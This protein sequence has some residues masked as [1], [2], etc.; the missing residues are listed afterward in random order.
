[1]SLAAHLSQTPPGPRKIRRSDRRP[2]VAVLG[3][4]HQEVFWRWMGF[5]AENFFFT[6]IYMG[7]DL[8]CLNFLGLV[9]VNGGV[10]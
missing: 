5:S 10:A 1:M 6:E 9:R 7:P 3:L 8:M 2:R 4:K